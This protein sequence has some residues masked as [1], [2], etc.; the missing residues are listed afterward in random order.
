MFVD[1]VKV[2]LK[3]GDGGDGCSSFRRERFR[4][5]GGPDGGDGGKGGDIILVGDEN[6]GDLTNYKFNPHVRAKN[7]EKGRGKDQYGR[8]GENCTLRLPLGT[9][10]ISEDTRAKAVDLIADEQRFLLL[11]GGKGGLGNL[12]FKS[13]VNRSPRESTPGQPGMEGCFTFILK[14]IADIGLVGFPNAGKSSLTGLL[15]QAH[16][17]IAPYPFTTLGPQVGVIDYPEHFDRITLAD[18]PGL[19]SGAHANRGLGHR[20]LRHIERCHLL[21]FVVDMAGIDGRN[22]RDDYH[23]LMKELELF[24]PNLTLKKRI[25]VANKIDEPQANTYLIHFEREVEEAVMPI[26]C[27]TSEGIVRLKKTLFPLIHDND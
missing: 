18:I 17:K 3:A 7:G 27:L 10:V 5:K 15:T 16:P 6:E 12:N 4:P 2:F 11:E 23:H 8:G 24:N 25:I 22:P 20:F 9:E 13:S 21:L 19:I 1:E 14:T 26:S